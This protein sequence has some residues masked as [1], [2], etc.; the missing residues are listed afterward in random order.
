MPPECRHRGC[1]HCFMISILHSQLI[2]TTMNRHFTTWVY[3]SLNH[4]LHITLSVVASSCCDWQICWNGENCIWR[5]VACSFQCWM[6]EKWMVGVWLAGMIIVTSWRELQLMLDT[7]GEADLV[8]DNTGRA[9]RELSHAA[10]HLLHVHSTGV[11]QLIR[12]AT[13]SGHSWVLNIKSGGQSNSHVETHQNAS[14]H[15]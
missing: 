13:V 15:S 2:K 12:P 5:H 3:F 7:Y 14:S 6:K 9:G 11:C 4:T 8:K 1:W 10:H